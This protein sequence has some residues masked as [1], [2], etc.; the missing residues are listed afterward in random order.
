MSEHGVIRGIIHEAIRIKFKQ[1]TVASEAEI[2]GSVLSKF[3][4]GEGAMKL[5][6][7]EK[8]FDMA[9]VIVITKQ[10]H[11]DNEAMLRGFSR[12]LLKT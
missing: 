11:E 10:E 6:S 12:R 1:A 4:A 7:L 3:L 9:G 5:D 2:D 8:I